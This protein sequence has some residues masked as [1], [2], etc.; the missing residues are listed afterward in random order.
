MSAGKNIQRATPGELDVSKTNAQPQFCRICAFLWRPGHPGNPS[1]PVG[2]CRGAGFS[3]T[4][5]GGGGG[6]NRCTIDLRAVSCSL[7]PLKFD[8]RT[9]AVA[10]VQVM[11]L[12]PVM[13]QGGSGQISDTILNQ[14][15]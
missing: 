4:W 6:D 10:L 12:V 11:S 3:G 7:N 15:N 14:N 9:T 1:G 5:Y 13:K 2:G 8:L